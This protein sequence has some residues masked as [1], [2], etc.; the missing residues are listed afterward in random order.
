MEEKPKDEVIDSKLWLTV[1]LQE[2]FYA[3]DCS[4]VDSIFEI[5]EPIT[6]LPKS[7]KNTVGVISYRE[8]MLPIIDLRRFFNMKTI[9][10]ENR[11]FEEMLQKRRQEHLDWVNTL[12]TC[13][14]QNE[15][16]TLP[17]DPHL[18]KF[19][20]WYDTYEP[21]NQVVKLYFNRIREP[22]IN[23]HNSAL[24][25]YAAKDEK[26]VQ[27]ILTE[28]TDKSMELVLKALDGAVEAFKGSFRKMCVAISNGVSSLGLLVDEIVVAEKFENLHQLGLNEGNTY[29]NTVGQDRKGANVLII[30][31]DSLLTGIDI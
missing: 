8:K 1:K 14:A 7:N 15:K 6:P 26:E 13:I 4:F 30:N 9:D 27:K 17:T 20:R 12:K 19:G 31:A 10:E 28:E 18:C 24:N 29:V 22:H 3:I 11:E 5:T 23:L 25:C 16:F 21:K 2:Q